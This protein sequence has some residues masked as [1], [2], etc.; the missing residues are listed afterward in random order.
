MHVTDVDLPC[1]VHHSKSRL[2]NALGV[3]PRKQTKY[4]TQVKPSSPKP[5][6]HRGFRKL[7]FQIFCIPTSPSVA[8]AFVVCCPLWM[9]CWACPWPR[10]AAPKPGVS[11][12][13]QRRRQGRRRRRRR[14]AR[15]GAAGCCWQCWSW[16][17]RCGWRNDKKLA[18]NRDVGT[19]GSCEAR[20]THR[21]QHRGELRSGWLS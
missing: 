7:H 20:K 2:P 14:R 4:K 3:P 5:Y 6:H 9:R 12:R 15:R 21:K 17:F 8:S 11:C 19:R 1:S 13:P 10:A 16:R 18:K